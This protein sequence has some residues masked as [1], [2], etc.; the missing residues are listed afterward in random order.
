MSLVDDSQ[1]DAEAQAF[2]IANFLVQGDD[3][4]KEVYS[5][6]ESVAAAGAGT[7]GFN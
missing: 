4:R 3:L 1:R 2:E 6:A 5:Q 7:S